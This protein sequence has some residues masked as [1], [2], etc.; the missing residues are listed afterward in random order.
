[1][2]LMRKRLL[3]AADVDPALVERAR[4]TP[5]FEVVDRPVA[6]AKRSWPAARDSVGRE[7]EYLQGKS[8]TQAVP[9]WA[10]L[11]IDGVRLV[12]DPPLLPLAG[13]HATGRCEAMISASNEVPS[14]RG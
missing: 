6:K 1:M 3:I 14:G 5:R 12:G 13:R 8:G 2:R 9:S 11:T 7:A 10:P 4:A